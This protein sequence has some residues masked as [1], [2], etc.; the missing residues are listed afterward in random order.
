MIN[1]F[2]TENVNYQIW[3]LNNIAPALFTFLI[4]LEPKVGPFIKEKK[5][6]SYE[7]RI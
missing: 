7:V 2:N 5:Q 3:G 4:C 6:G 1:W